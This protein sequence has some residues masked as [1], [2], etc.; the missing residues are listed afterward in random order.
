MHFICASYK[1]QK[2]SFANQSIVSIINYKCLVEQELIVRQ[3]H[4]QIAL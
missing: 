4:E 2:H 3:L 1:D